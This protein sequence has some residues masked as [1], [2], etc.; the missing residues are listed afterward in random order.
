MAS[1]VHNSIIAG[2]GDALLQSVIHFAQQ[3]GVQRIEGFIH[4]FDDGLDFESVARW[5]R[6]NGFIVTGGTLLYEV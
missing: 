2:L 1:H 6:K 3:K 5:Y 4:P